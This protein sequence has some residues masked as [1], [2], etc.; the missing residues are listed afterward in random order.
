MGLFKSKEE[1]ERE[2]L[3]LREEI[4]KSMVKTIYRKWF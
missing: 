3:E 4:K 2:K 1:K